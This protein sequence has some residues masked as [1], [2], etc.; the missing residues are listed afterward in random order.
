[1]FVHIFAN[2]FRSDTSGNCAKLA[3]FVHFLVESVARFV[4]V[5]ADGCDRIT[6]EGICNLNVVYLINSIMNMFEL[7]Y[8][9]VKQW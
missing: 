6:G 1:M 4:S 7:Y 2:Q 8:K 5:L 9:K 3:L